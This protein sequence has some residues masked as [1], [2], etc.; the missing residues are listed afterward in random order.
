MRLVRRTV[1]VAAAVMFAA[2]LAIFVLK[3]TLR[4]G[5]DAAPDWSDEVAAILFV[6]VVF[7]GAAFMVPLEDHIRFDLVMRLLPRGAQRGVAILRHLAVIGLFAAGLPAA[8]GYIIFL[9]SQAT[10]VLGLE[11]EWVYA[12]FGGFLVAVPMRSVMALWALL[13]RPPEAG[14]IP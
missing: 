6:W 11:L 12:C 7:W 14:V 4:Y 9:H 1:E 5:F 3:V 8:I 2:M 13:R 10:P